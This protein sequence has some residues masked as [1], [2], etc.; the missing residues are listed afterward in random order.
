D[1]AADVARHYGNSALADSILDALAA[2]GKDAADLTHADLAPV[3]EFHIGGRAATQ[4]L[5]AQLAL[6]PDMH[7]LD[8]GC[9][10]GGASRYFAQTHGCRVTGIDLTEDYVRVAELLSQRLGLGDRVS[11][12]QASALALPFDAAS[13]DGAYMLHVG[14]NIRDKAALFAEIRRVLRPGAQFAVYD[15]MRE[16]DGELSFPVPWASR[17]DISFVDDAA[18]YRRALEAA[19][20]AVEVARSRRDFAIAFF[21]QMRARAAGSGGPPPLGLHLLMGASSP[22]KVANMIDMLERGLIAPTEMIARAV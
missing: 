4:A 15:V 11:Y 20:F 17:A 2:A 22:Q 9:G 12:R 19:G 14:M 16:G 18:T 3:D 5:A 1:T 21:R 10:P 8:V 13:F 7:L 6:R